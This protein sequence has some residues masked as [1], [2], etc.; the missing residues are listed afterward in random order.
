MFRTSE[1]SAASS[2][3][4]AEAMCSYVSAAMVDPSGGRLPGGPRPLG[5]LEGRERAGEDEAAAEE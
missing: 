1:S 2:S 5:L 3:M 4:I